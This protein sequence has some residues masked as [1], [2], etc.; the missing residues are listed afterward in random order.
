MGGRKVSI[1]GLVEPSEDP[2]SV[3]LQIR[4]EPKTK[5]ASN[6]Q[7]HA[8]G[9]ES[10]NSKKEV[11]LAKKESAFNEENKKKMKEAAL[12]LIGMKAK[13]AQAKAEL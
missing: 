7:N 6:L 3:F 13:Q 8:E 9:E 2:E 12:K 10:E 5:S 1:D 11:E 4:A